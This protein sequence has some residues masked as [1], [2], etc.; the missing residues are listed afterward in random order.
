MKNWFAADAGFAEIYAGFGGW[1]GCQSRSKLT[2]KPT[3][4]WSIVATERLTE[5]GLPLQASIRRTAR[6]KR[7]MMRNGTSLCG[8]S[9]LL[10]RSTP[11][12]SL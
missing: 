6:V 5:L 4:I 11:L 7:L 1:L 12:P 2:V 10:K 3:P 9:G 8:S